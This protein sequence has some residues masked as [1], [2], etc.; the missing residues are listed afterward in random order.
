MSPNHVQG[1]SKL[2]NTQKLS[3]SV[4]HFYIGLYRTIAILPF[5]WVACKA[6]E[7][8]S[9]NGELSLLHAQPLSDHLMS[10]HLC[11]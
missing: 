10:D 1:A 4:P 5:W 3:S 11:G 9:L 7:S 6:V 2:Y 8:R